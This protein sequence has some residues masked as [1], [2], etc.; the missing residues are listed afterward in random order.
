MGRKYKKINYPLNYNQLQDSKENRQEKILRNSGNI[1]T[2]QQKPTY[3]IK[4]IGK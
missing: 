1:E 2:P 4:K 3:T